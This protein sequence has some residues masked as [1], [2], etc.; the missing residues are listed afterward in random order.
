[1]WEWYQYFDHD[2]P[3]R[4]RT[5]AGGARWRLKRAEGYDDGNGGWNQASLFDEPLL[6]GR[7]RGRRVEL[8]ERAVTEIADHGWLLKIGDYARDVSFYRRWPRS[9]ADPPPSEVRVRSTV[10]ADL[11]EAAIYMRKTIS[12]GEIDWRM[13]EM[14]PEDFYA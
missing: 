12:V 1:M 14:T 8:L 3:T 10:L 6:R 2:R 7:T 9:A 4:I 11:W 13:T 5:L